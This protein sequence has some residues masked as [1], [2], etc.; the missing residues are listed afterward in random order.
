V[1]L[2]G[3]LRTYARDL[4][5]PDRVAAAGFFRPERVTSLLDDHEARRSD[6]S[7]AIW[8]L[9]CFQ[10]WYERFIAPDRVSAPAAVARRWGLS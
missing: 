1:W 4:L 9:I 10:L 7:F 8:S 6:H 2:A 5:A 3:S